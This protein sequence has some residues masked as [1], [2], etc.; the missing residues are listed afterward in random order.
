VRDHI[1]IICNKIKLLDRGGTPFFPLM[2]HVLG[3]QNH[4]ED[5]TSLDESDSPVKGSVVDH[6]GSDPALVL[7]RIQPAGLAPE[8]RFKL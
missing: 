3:K 1:L 2:Q 4:L 6:E 5:Y 7:A 8:T